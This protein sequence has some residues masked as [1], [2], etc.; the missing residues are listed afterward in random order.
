MSMLKIEAKVYDDGRTK[1]SFKDSTDVNKLLSK[2][3]RSDTIS[4]LE[5]FENVYGDFS[6]FDFDDAQRQLAGARTVFTELP[7]EIRREFNGDA[8][9]FFGYVN[10]PANVGRLAELLPAL[11]APG[12]QRRVIND[13]ATP[14]AVT[15]AAP[16]EAETPA[17]PETPPEVTPEVPPTG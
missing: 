14:R 4:H 7:S 6:D 2:A 11:A 1:Q 3:Q 17:E 15:A 10:D 13:G 12:R 8:K 9:Q 5:K 16:V